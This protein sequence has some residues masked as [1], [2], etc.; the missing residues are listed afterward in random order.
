MLRAIKKF[1]KMFKSH[2]KVSD[3]FMKGRLIG[4]PV[5]IYVFLQKYVD[6][7]SVQIHTTHALKQL[8]V[9]STFQCQ[10][11][12]QEP[13]GDKAAMANPY[14]AVRMKDMFQT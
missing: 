14:Y 13:E 10:R 11:L 1:W 7:L 2:G 12:L 9:L 3:F 5:L 6:L 8:K 4:S